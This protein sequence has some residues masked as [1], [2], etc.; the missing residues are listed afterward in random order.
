M[1]QFPPQVT[2]MAEAYWSILLP[3]LETMGVWDA[4]GVVLR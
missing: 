2:W 3:I 1:G 4:L